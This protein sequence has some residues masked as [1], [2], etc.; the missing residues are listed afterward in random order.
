MVPTRT[1]RRA[2]VV[3]PAF[4]A[5]CLL[6]PQPLLAAGE[7][8]AHLVN[9]GWLQKNLSNPGVLVLDAS[10]AQVYTAQH[11]PGAVHVDLLSYGAQEKSLAEMEQ[12]YRSW[13]VS[14]DK[15]IVLYDGGGTYLATRV[16]FSLYYHGFPARSL[17]V[18]DGGLAKWQ[19][20]KLPVTKDITP[21]PK[22]GTFRI[23]GAN[24]ALRVRLPEFLAAS[25]DPVNHV[26]VEALGPEWHFGQVS[27]FGRPGHP[28]NGVMLPP[29]DFF[30]PDKTF[31]SPEEL[32]RMLAY[33]RIG[34]EQQVHSY[35]GG[36]VAASVP[37]FA[38][39]HIL[40]YPKVKLYVES[41]MGYLS[42]ERELPHW[43]YDAPFL[44]RG[45]TWL[46]GWGGQMIRTYVGA[47]ISVVDLRPA[48]AFLAGHVPFALNVP[49]EAFKANLGAPDTL[50]ALLGAA[51]VDASHEAVVLSGAGLT[52]DAAL[53]FL[54]LE[55]LGQA[56]VSVLIDSMGRWTDLGFALAKG[57]TA[58]GPKKAPRDLTIPPT[59]YPVNVRKDV[60]VADAKASQGLYPRVFVASGESLPTRAQDGKT[61]HVPSTRLLNA[62]GT[63]KAA[64][65]IWSLLAK[66]GV[67]RYAEL[68]CVADDPGE[69]AVNYF[70]LK[71]MGFPDVKVLVPR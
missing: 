34:P 62:D 66:A 36:G 20:A 15:T 55:K 37:Y 10:A 48:D 16:F 3:L 30:N 22:P 51:G 27:P 13:G 54:A 70:I 64:K 18:L 58:V 1:V 71:L 60:I 52:K 17:F 59:T 5:A 45:A 26:L 69:A 44:M 19:E 41:E 2:F 57:P 39:K 67:P 38:L 42:D 9:V 68:V 23:K 7:G 31:K 29:A 53:A 49:A 14:P 50:A 11:I 4:L 8:R 12:L 65:D 40:G 47:R 28:P 24:E 61:V 25:G 6:M 56:R 43:T 33:L 21:G 63:P 46:Q 35:C 32:R